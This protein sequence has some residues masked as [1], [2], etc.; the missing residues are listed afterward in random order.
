M[1]IYSL[2]IQRHTRLLLK[3]LINGMLEHIDLI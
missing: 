3:A 1:D 2:L